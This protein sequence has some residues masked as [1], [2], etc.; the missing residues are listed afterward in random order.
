MNGGRILGQ[1]PDDLTEKGPLNIGRGRFI[2]T[3]SWDTIMNSVAEWAGVTGEKKLSKVLPNREK[4]Q[5]YEN[6]EMFPPPPPSPLTMQ[7]S[8]YPTEFRSPNPTSLPSKTRPTKSPTKNQS[9]SSSPSKDR[10][11]TKSPS[12]SPSPSTS[13]LWFIGKASIVMNINE[14]VPQMEFSHTVGTGADDVRVSVYMDDCETQLSQNDP[15]TV[16]PTGTVL[17]SGLAKYVINLDT[18]NIS[19]SVVVNNDRLQLCAKLELLDGPSGLSVTFRKTRVEFDFDLSVGYFQVAYS[20]EELDVDNFDLGDLS[21][22]QSRACQCQTSFD[23]DKSPTI[24]DQNEKFGVCVYASSSGVE[25]VNFD[26][27]VRSDNGGFEYSPISLDPNTND[28]VLHL[29]T[30]ITTNGVVT[31][32]TAPLVTGLFESNSDQITVS[33]S[34]QLRFADQSESAL[35]QNAEVRRYEV[36]I[37]LKTKLEE[38]TSLFASII[39]FFSVIFE[40]I[41]Q[42]FL[43][44]F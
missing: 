10:F 36:S 30:Q 44:V 19:N 2:P 5:L 17:V 23:C 41:A 14:G 27:T 3:T 42:M 20:I 9:G 37:L 15:V 4:F 12:R 26:L 29:G 32:V 35:K 8:S 7:P 1:Y 28:Q 16:A 31:K 43:I 11:T 6:G 18:T 13:N 39:S 33:G 24:L 34:G 25:F 21:F 38:E 40:T 22:Y